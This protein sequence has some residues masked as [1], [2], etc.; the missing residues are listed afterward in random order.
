LETSAFAPTTGRSRSR[1]H[2]RACCM[3]RKLVEIFSQFGRPLC[4]TSILSTP[5]RAAGLFKKVKL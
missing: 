1:R 5:K 3:Y 4:S 2:F